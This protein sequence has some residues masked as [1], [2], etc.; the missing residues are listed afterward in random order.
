[1]FDEAKQGLMLIGIGLAIA[2]GC[3]LGIYG[4]LVSR[5]GMFTAGFYPLLFGLVG[6]GVGIGAVV[7]LIYG[8]VDDEW[9]VAGIVY[10]VLII[11]LGVIGLILTALIA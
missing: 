4:I 10:L 1:M 11:I 6:A 8:A 9:E 5:T 3:M 7:A 2:V